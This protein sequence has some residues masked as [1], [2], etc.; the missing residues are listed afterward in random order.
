MTQFVRHKPTLNTVNHEN[1]TCNFPKFLIESG[2]YFF[3][4]S[5]I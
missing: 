1:F 4:N 3:M 5:K 2:V